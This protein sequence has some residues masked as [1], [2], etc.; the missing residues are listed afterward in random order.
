MDA[1]M[2]ILYVLMALI[3]VKILYDRIFNPSVHRTPREVG[4]DTKE[5]AKNKARAKKA[6]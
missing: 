4:H 3:V 1:I 2:A 5:K 6:D